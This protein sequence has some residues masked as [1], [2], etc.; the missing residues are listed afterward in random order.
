MRRLSS[1]FQQEQAFTGSG[2]EEATA[3]TFLDEELVIVIRVEPKQGKLKSIL[4]TRLAVTAS[5][6]TPELCEDWSDLVFEVDRN[7]LS[8][9]L[10]MDNDCCLFAVEAGFDSRVA[11]SERR[12]KAIFSNL[13]D[14][15]RSDR[16]IHRVSVITE[17]PRG[18]GSRN[19]QLLP[20]VATANR[21]FAV[22]GLDFQS[23]QNTWISKP[24][25]LGSGRADS[26]K[27][28]NSKG[29][30]CTKQLHALHG[31]LL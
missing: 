10:N 23:I 5:R 11:V 31:K 4:T 19:D 30:S 16:K 26:G 9:A 17:L 27:R 13:H 21:E 7:L 8:N 24:F 22:F 3:S 1:R 20:R 15:L 14:P 25:G 6:V 18:I 12:H 28:N 2:R 29:Y